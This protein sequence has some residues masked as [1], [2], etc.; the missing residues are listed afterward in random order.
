VVSGSGKS[1]L[2]ANR[3]IKMNDRL[4]TLPLSSLSLCAAA[5]WLYH[6]ASSGKSQLGANRIIKM[7]NRLPADVL[8][9]IFDYYSEEETEIYPLETLLQVCKSWSEAAVNC[10]RLWTRLKISLVDEWHVKRWLVRLP[11]RLERAGDYMPLE[12]T[13]S[14]WVGWPQSYFVDRHICEGCDPKN[15][16]VH[17]CPTE[18]LL[19]ILTG[20]D[21]ELCK[22]WKSLAIHSITDLHILSHL[23]Y[24]TPI[25]TA[26][27]YE[28]VET[29]TRPPHLPSLPSL[30]TLHIIKCLFLDLPKLDSIRELVLDSGRYLPAK[31]PGFLDLHTATNLE[32]LTIKATPTEDI[33]EYRFPDR[34][35]NLEFLAFDGIEVPANMRTFQAPNLRCLSLT[36]DLPHICPIILDSSIQFSTL[37]ELRLTW[38][39]FHSYPLK[40]FLAPTRELLVRCTGLT[41]IGGNEASLTTIVRLLWKKTGEMSNYVETMAGKAITITQRSSYMN[42]HFLLDGPEKKKNLIALVYGVGL[43]RPDQNRKSVLWWLDQ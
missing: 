20:V 7:N 28:R 38:I 32:R 14:Q 22:R 35:P 27:R 19:K 41:H 10:R 11:R 30:R 13:L 43:A 16:D 23:S 1:Q 8:C 4:T 29:D 37:R 5:I 40:D 15:R 36:S 31:T 6:L 39:D 25:L 18:R 3:I 2:G 33:A 42:N 26:L 34:L 9:E 24:P 21:G 12:I 17:R